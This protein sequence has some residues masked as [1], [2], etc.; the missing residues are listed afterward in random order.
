MGLAKIG[1]TN[2]V[3]PVEHT[4]AIVCNTV[5]PW[6]LLPKGTGNCYHLLQD[7]DGRPPGWCYQ[8]VRQ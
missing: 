5:P 2:N 6:E 8:R 4:V 7:V 3:L 1:C